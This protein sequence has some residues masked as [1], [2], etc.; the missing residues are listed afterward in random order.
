LRT[1]FEA[2]PPAN[3]AEFET[4]IQAVAATQGWPAA[5]KI[6]REYGDRF[7]ESVSQAR[8]RATALLYA[9][10]SDAYRHVVAKVLTSASSTNAWNEQ[11]D[12]LNIVLLGATAVSPEQITRCATLI[13]AFERGFE[14]VTEYK[15]NTGHRALGSVLLRLGQLTSSLEHLEIAGK[16]FAAGN[17]RA[18]VLFPKSICLHRLGRADEARATFDEAE[19][20]TRWRL[21][22]QLPESEGCLTPDERTCLILRREAQTLL[23]VK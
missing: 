4:F 5:A 17:H 7:T 12:I 14:N 16:K 15:Q 18:L 11:Q 6:Y 9:G 2:K 3:S 10:D 22:K 21:L 20:I 23:G 8:A 1:I 19:A 13:Q